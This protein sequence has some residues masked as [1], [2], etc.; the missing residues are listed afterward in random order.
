MKTILLSIALFAT[1][2]SIN[3][4]ERV[5]LDMGK[6]FTGIKS[7]APVDIYL[8]N[9]ADYAGFVVYDIDPQVKDILNIS[10]IDGSLTFSIDNSIKEITGDF[11]KKVSK[12]KVYAPSPIDNISISG[13]GDIDAA[14]G[15][16][17]ADNV[18][19]KIT[20]SGDM[21]LKEIKTAA[22]SISVSGSG[23]IEIEDLTA[24]NAEI[25]LNGSG[26]VKI[27][28][29]T[30]ES[31]DVKISGSGDAK[32]DGRCKA[33]Y[34]NVSGSGDISCGKLI[35]DIVT[36]KVTGSGDVNCYAAEMVTA[37]ASGSGDI[38]VHGEPATAKISGRKDNINIIK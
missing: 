28:R 29:L 7:S 20:G 10:V 12:I 38:D 34:L 2:I 23:D 30:A 3:A 17:L 32:I 11:Y 16:T 18:N 6:D 36:V 13:S 5:K 24:E 14:R 31:A 25:K 27:K 19:L 15:L 26:D 4:R 9:K 33:A 37:T 22:I 21:E 35:A 1:A 8:S